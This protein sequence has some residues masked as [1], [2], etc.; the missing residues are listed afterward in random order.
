MTRTITPRGAFLG[1]NSLRLRMLLA[2]LAWTAVGIAG[3]WFSAT[4]LFAKHVEMQYHEE[5][6]VHIVELAALVEIGPGG[7]LTMDRPLS[8]PR[9]LVPLSGFY[10]EVA[11]HGRPGLKSPS[12]TRGSLD[13]STAHDTSIHHHVEAGPTGPTITYGTMRQAGDG[14][15]VHFMIATDE[16]LLNEAIAEFTQELTL[17]LAALAMALALTG[18]AVVSFGL[19]P[20]DRLAH[21]TARLRSG[22]ATSLEGKYPNEIAPLVDDVNAYV[23]HNSRIVERARV[24]AGN[25][26]HALRTP[27]AVITDEAERLA[28]REGASDAAEVFLG[29]GQVMVRQIEY[30]LA[31]ARSTVGFRGPGIT[32]R[33]AEVLPPIISAMRRLHRERGFDVDIEEDADTPLR[34]DPVDLSEVL[35]ILIDNAAKWA[36]RE[37]EVMARRTGDRV[38]FSIGDDGPGLSEEQLRHAFEVGTR[39]DPE[40]AGSGLGLAIARDIADAY[41]LEIDLRAK[42]GGAGL[43]ATVTV[44]VAG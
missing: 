37:V 19:R 24:E 6:E 27:L 5:L 12:M 40:S 38:E 10:W 44:P 7:A 21:A 35:S 20:L 11:V 13:P 8:D 22:H 23:D 1:W 15:N 9:Y 18:M 28:S 43:C 31:R 36:S 26:A 25:L 17:W 30:Q 3:I 41:D 2:A 14:T 29:Q 34:I 33:A 32:S 39:F 16:R 4:S 42:T